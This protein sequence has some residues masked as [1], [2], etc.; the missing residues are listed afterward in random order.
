MFN[1]V[2]GVCLIELRS[3]NSCARAYEHLQQDFKNFAIQN[4][5]SHITLIMEKSPE[6]SR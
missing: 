6:G 5:W 3:A 1:R 4:G 2:E